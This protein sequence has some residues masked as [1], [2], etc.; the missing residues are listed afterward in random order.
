MPYGFQ[1]DMVRTTKCV[2]RELFSRAARRVGSLKA[3]EKGARRSTYHPPTG[4][5]NAAHVAQRS[6]EASGYGSYSGCRTRG[7]QGQRSRIQGML[8]ARLHSLRT[9]TFPVSRRNL[10]RD[11]LRISSRHSPSGTRAS[12]WSAASSPCSPSD[13]LFGLWS[14]WCRLGVH[15]RHG[16]SD[17]R[18]FCM[19]SKHMWA[20][21]TTPLSRTTSVLSETH[22]TPSSR[23]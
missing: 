18:S 20:S 15:C 23:A 6:L 11:G 17:A 16:P 5:R 19:S 3:R 21:C 7:Q 10:Q 2:G 22:S 12:T 1:T 13:C 4:P 8:C 9:Y 14:A